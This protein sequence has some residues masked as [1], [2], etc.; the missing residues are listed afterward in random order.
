MIETAVLVKNLVQSIKAI[1]IVTINVKET[2]SVE[3]TIVVK[4]FQSLLTAVNQHLMV[5]V[6][7]Y[8]NCKNVEL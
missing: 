8:K 2:L 1:V 4:V 3:G 7:K 5:Q 6:R